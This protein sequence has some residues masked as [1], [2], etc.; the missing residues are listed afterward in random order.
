MISSRRLPRREGEVGPAAGR[1]VV[2]DADAVPLVEKALGH[3]RADEARAAGHEV[4]R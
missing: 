4:D 2:E 3:V 1:E